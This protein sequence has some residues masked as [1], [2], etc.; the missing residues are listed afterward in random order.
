MDEERGKIL[1]PNG[2]LPEKRKH[3]YVMHPLDYE[4]SGCPK[5]GGTNVTWSE[6]V[7]HLWCYDCKVD[8]IPEFNGIFDGPIPLQLTEMMGIKLDRVNLETGKRYKPTDPEFNTT[9]P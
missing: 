9:W 8:Y 4:I 3:C 2:E 6:Y 7:H 5:C 1:D